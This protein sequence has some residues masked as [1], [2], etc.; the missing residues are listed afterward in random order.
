MRRNADNIRAA[1]QSA[2][3]RLCSMVVPHGRGT[4]LPRFAK[5]LFL[6]L[7]N[8]LRL[9]AR[10]PGTAPIR[11]ATPPEPLGVER[12]L[13]ARTLGC[14]DPAPD[15]GDVLAVPHNDPPANLHTLP[16]PSKIVPRAQR[17]GT[18]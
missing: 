1:M 18:R 6:S 11:S 7:V 17:L 5:L 8:P 4:L 3:R 13:F 2:F 16:S 15:S 14:A 9:P 10:T 12:A